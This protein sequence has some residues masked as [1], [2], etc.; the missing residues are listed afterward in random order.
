MQL[1]FTLL[2]SFARDNGSARFSARINFEHNFSARGRSTPASN[3]ANRYTSSKVPTSSKTSGKK[4]QLPRLRTNYP[5]P[6]PFVVSHLATSRVTVT[7]FARYLGLSAD[8]FGEHSAQV[9]SRRRLP[10]S[11]DN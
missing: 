5:L 3:P 7:H 10:V 9:K 6:L 4:A 1:R 8:C 11:G 2:V